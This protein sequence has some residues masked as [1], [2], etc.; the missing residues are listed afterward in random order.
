MPAIA[1]TAIDLGTA[2]AGHCLCNFLA[3]DALGRYNHSS[4]LLG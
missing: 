2:Q 3:N 1:E 4:A